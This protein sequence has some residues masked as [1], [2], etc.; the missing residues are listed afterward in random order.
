[1]E[2]DV[3]TNPKFIAAALSKRVVM[4]VEEVGTYPHCFGYL[5]NGKI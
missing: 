5:G 4:V 3:T 1:M 2:L